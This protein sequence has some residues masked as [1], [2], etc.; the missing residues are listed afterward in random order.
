LVV[1][2]GFFGF[3]HQYNW[4]NWNIVERGVN[5][6]GYNNIS[7]VFMFVSNN[8]NDYVNRSRNIC[9][10]NDHDYVPH[11]EQEPLNIWG[12][13]SSP[14]VLTGVRVGRCLV[15]CVVFC[16]S[17]VVLLSFCPC[18]CCYCI[19]CPSLIYVFWLP[20]LLSVS[21]C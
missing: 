18:W 11:V 10:T 21:V 3:L 1:F 16:R 14:L 20:P 6:H 4:Y 15:F 8:S 9:V 13:M 7:L 12:H 17:L 2:S 5:H 19:I